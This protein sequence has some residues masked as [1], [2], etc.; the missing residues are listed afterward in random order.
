MTV[1]E[2][3]IIPPS[4]R[5]SAYIKDKARVDNKA[6]IDD[7]VGAARKDEVKDA[8]NAE[9]DTTTNVETIRDINEGKVEYEDNEGEEI[10]VDGDDGT[11]NEVYERRQTMTMMRLMRMA[12]LMRPR[13]MR[14]MVTP[15]T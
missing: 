6:G 1:Q 11:D 15:K 5:W 10:K 13:I 2:K 7:E 9:V 12:R 3:V 8:D 4:Q 14:W